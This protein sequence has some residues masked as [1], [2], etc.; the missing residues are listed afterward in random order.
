A[1]SFWRGGYERSMPLDEPRAFDADCMVRMMDGITARIAQEGNAVVVGRGAPYFLRER[2]DTF[3]VFLYAPRPAQARR[4]V[5]GGTHPSDGEDS[6]CSVYG[7]RRAC[8]KHYSNAACPT[9]SFDHWITNTVT[10]TEKALAT[11]V[12]PM[13]LRQDKPVAA[14]ADIRGVALQ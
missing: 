8:I 12:E 13:R 2:Q 11:I 14:A 7:E 10:G 1:K 4:S 9:G 6:G 3:R 5:G